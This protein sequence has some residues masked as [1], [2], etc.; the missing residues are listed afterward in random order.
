MIAIIS[1]PFRVSK[2]S[3]FLAWKLLG[4]ITLIL[5]FRLSTYAQENVCNCSKNFERLIGKLET[6]YIAYQLIKNEIEKNYESHK[7]RFKTLAAETNDNN[8]TK[9]LQEFLSF[10]HDGHLFVSEYPDFPAADL[11]KTKAEIKQNM[12]DL[13]RMHPIGRSP[14]EGYWTDGQ[15]KFVIVQ[16]K[17]S[18]IPF[19]WVAIILETKDSTKKG[20]IKFAVDKSGNSWE[21][22]YYTN[23]Y[24]YRYVKITPYKEN[25]ILSVWGGILWGKLSGKDDSVYNPVLPTVKKIDNENVLLTIPSFLVD[26]KDF[27]KVLIENIETL[28]FANNLIIDIRGNTGGNGIYFN[29]MRLYYE[30][31]AVSSRGL[32]LSSADNITYFEKFASTRSGDPYVPVIKAMREKPGGIV[33]GPDFRDLGLTPE[34]TNIQK[35]VILTDRGNMSAAETFVLYSKAVSNKVI[36]M[37][38]NTGG[39]VDFNNINMIKIGCDKHGIYFGYPTYTLHDKV[40]EHGY[41]KNGIPPDV[42]IDSGVPDKIAFVLEYLKQK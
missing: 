9:L 11:E 5:F 12:Y 35:V 8:C 25:S 23:A 6:N 13:N 3:V 10:F 21:G 18:N 15:S 38:D 37:G 20:E 34:K 29:L 42:K 22:I 39:V 1:H 7:F 41:N 26:A 27:D 36:T 30:K 14:I 32:A 33:A 17:N 31:P 16:N 4:S 19:E 2:E 24:A 28:L 40:I